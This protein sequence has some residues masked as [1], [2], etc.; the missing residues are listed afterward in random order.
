[1]VQSVISNIISAYSD[2]V[3]RDVFQ[4][5]PGK[6]IVILVSV[7]QMETPCVQKN[8]AL[9]PVFQNQVWKH[10]LLFILSSYIINLYIIFNTY[11]LYFYH[12]L[13]LVVVKVIFCLIT[14]I[15]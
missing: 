11:S 10:N 13:F 4:G 1:M 3:L 8:S 2:P 6:R 7:H 5:T 15:I 12:F 9:N 14:Q